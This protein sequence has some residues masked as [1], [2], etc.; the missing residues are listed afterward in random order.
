MKKLNKIL[1]GAFVFMALIS[2]INISNVV[3]TNPLDIPTDEYSGTLDPGENAIRFRNQ[4]QIR[5]DCNQCICINIECEALKIG[6]KD[7]ILELNT[8]GDCLM[9]MTC[10]EEQAELGLLNGN[11]IQTRT[12]N[13]YTYREGFCISIECNCSEIQARLR[14]KASIHNRNGVWAYYQGDKWV[15]V[16]TTIED[17]YLTAEV[18]HFSSWTV[19]IP[20]AGENLVFYV[21]IAAI[22][23]VIA[24]G[25]VAFLRKRVKQ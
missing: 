8:S 5:I 12:R 20:T 7:F 2:I 16:P 17:D 15:P 13:R 18:D 10:T 19:L 11:S 4:T 22:I 1:L 21:G 6:A 14:I 3:A 9:N 23:G 24:V 25:S